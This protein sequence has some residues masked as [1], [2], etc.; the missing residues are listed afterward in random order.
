MASFMRMRASRLTG[1]KFALQWIGKQCG[2]SWGQKGRLHMTPVALGVAP[3][4]LNM[5]A[6][7]PTM[8]EGTILKWL[9]KEGDTIEPGDVLCEIQ[10]DKAVVSFDTEEEGV[11]AK[12]IVP[13]N[14]PNISIGTLIALM[15]EEG[16]DWKDVEV[17]RACNFLLHAVQTGQTL[18]TVR[19]VK[20]GPSVLR[21][22]T[23]YGLS[24]TDL[25][26]TGP[27]GILIKG[28]VL[29]HIAEKGLKPLPSEKLSVPTAASQAPPPTPTPVAPPPVAPPAV[30][31]SLVAAP[32]RPAPS[33]GDFVDIPNT[34]MRS[35]IAKR[36]TQSKQTIPHV[37]TSMDCQL[38]GVMKLRRDFA[39]DKV[40]ISVNDII[41][42]AVAV[43]LHSVP[44]ANVIWNDATQ[45][46]QQASQADVSVAVATDSGLITPIVKDAG[47]LGLLE[48]SSQV[49]DLAARAKE[50]KLQL[51]EFQG[52]TFTISNL[53]MYGISHFTAV[54]NPPQCCIL[55]VGG[56]RAT[57][58][59]DS[60]APAAAMT[61][62]LSSDARAVD[63]ATAARFL[64]AFREVVENPFLM[65]SQPPPKAASFLDM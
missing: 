26:P 17:L 64:D 20:I 34:N 47:S 12:I 59:A 56:S 40:K 53:G 6:L 50:G 19:T 25:R 22:L 52:G 42:K 28:D 48:I 2:V 54:I 11:L 30:A 65:V 18:Q 33:D 58:D 13:D 36:L 61:V 51:Q 29:K 16:E 44:E 62:T 1:Q 57:V 4:K 32:P 9:K 46:A 14:T 31:P 39:A 38:A 37:Y 41:I 49:K 8:T 3:T 55:A 15:V 21:L 45:S 7:S 10:T 24:P 27:H 43:A 60:G 35:V 63:D 5:P 23:E